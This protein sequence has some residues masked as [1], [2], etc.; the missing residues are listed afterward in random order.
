MT[1]LAY[2]TTVQA[3]LIWLSRRPIELLGNRIIPWRRA[4]G[5]VAY[6]VPGLISL[7]VRLRQL[8]APSGSDGASV[9]LPAR[10][11]SYERIRYVVG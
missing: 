11:L 2:S 6:R 8:E 10:L 5:E 3:A 4:S 7:A 9:F 1:R